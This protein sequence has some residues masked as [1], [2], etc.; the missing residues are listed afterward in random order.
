MNVSSIA[1]LVAPVGA[2]TEPAP[3]HH[4]TEDQRTLIHAVKA[5]NAS[6]M[7]GQDNELTFVFERGSHRTVARIVNKQTREVV[8]QIPA[9]Y[10]L[11]MAEEMKRG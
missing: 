10:V 6:E 8:K 11:R 4:L 5:V 1:N 9:E 2:P 7:L 3:A